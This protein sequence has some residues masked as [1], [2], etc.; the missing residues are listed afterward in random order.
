MPVY[1][2]GEQLLAG[3]RLSASARV[4]DQFFNAWSHGIV[5]MDLEKIDLDFV[6]GETMQSEFASIDPTKNNTVTLDITVNRGSQLP[7]LVE[8]EFC[9]D[10]LNRVC[11]WPFLRQITFYFD[12]DQDP[13]LR[14]FDR[15]GQPV[16][17]F[18]RQIPD[19]TKSGTGVCP[20]HTMPGSM[21]AGR[22]VY[23]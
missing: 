21:P 19:C 7:T 6:G 5:F 17:S 3:G 15:N 23:H 10:N 18:Q 4:L 2:R 13:R 20:S 14:Y 11:K 1:T 16:S 12:P 22:A 9:Q 8:A